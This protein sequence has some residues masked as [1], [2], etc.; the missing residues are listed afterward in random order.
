MLRK[1]SYIP[2]VNRNLRF[3]YK[4][5]KICNKRDTIRLAENTQTVLATA[6]LP[7]LKTTR[8]RSDYI[9]AGGFYMG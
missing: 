5:Y 9:H 3:K 2:Q 6:L 4:N 1:E 7:A 8:D